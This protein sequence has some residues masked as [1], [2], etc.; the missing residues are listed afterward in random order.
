[1]SI[2]QIAALTLLAPL[3]AFSQ[4]TLSGAAWFAST[5]TGGTSISQAYA[6]GAS[7]T[8]GG[9]Q[10]WDLWM[11]LDPNAN[12]PINGPS[13]AQS[14]ISIPLL[15]G[16]AYKYYIMAQG[17]CCTLSYSGLN[18]FFDGNSAT[19]AISVFGVLNNP[20]FRLNTNADTFSLQIEPAP[21]SG[22]GYYTANGITVVL[23]G[24]QWNTSG[25]LYLCQAFSFT[26]G[27]Q[28]TAVGSFS[29]RVFPAAGLTSS[30][31]S[32]APGTSTTLTG[33]G[34]APS[35][36]V[37]IYIGGLSLRPTATVTADASG[38]FSL[39]QP[40]PP[41]SYGAEDIYAVGDTSGNLGATSISVTPALIV[42]PRH[43]SPGSTVTVQGSGFGSSEMVQVYWS[44]PRQLLGSAATNATGTFAGGNA[45]QFAI[46]LNAPSGTNAIAAIGQTTGAIA[47]GS[48]RVH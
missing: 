13:D 36:E 39:Q 37:K 31:P 11:S 41:A 35:E 32:A 16:H 6:D 20:A 43:A 40:V 3:S 14:S 5:P 38:A 12:H 9:D 15:A 42:S 10:W 45:V 8:L 18:L 2:W 48:I 22:T 34:F 28:P 27:S 23:T 30:L 4:V 7:N 33:S 19:P 26:P 1:M 44:N 29:L 47:L 24:Y 21:A 25:N 17:P 46:P